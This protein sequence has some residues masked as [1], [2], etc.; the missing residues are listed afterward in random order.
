[1]NL[2]ITL[3]A[4]TDT[5]ARQQNLRIYSAAKA[6]LSFKLLMLIFI[7]MSESFLL[8]EFIGIMTGNRRH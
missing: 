8:M 4:S 2:A 5:K 1:M 3:I 6:I 7:M